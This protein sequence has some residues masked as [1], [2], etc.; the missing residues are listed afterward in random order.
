MTFLFKVDEVVDCL[1][2][3]LAEFGAQAW[4]ENVHLPQID[5]V[6]IVNIARVKEILEAHFAIS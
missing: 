3:F 4:Q 6:I 1:N 5:T 2:V